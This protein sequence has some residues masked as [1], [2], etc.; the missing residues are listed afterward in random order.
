[1]KSNPRARIGE[2]AK[3]R[4]AGLTLAL[5]ILLA[6]VAPSQA[7]VLAQDDFSDGNYTSSPSWTTV[8]PGL[9][10]VTG[11][12]LKMYNAS[13]AA[14]LALG[15]TMASNTPLMI[16]L[17]LQNEIFNA[18]GHWF[19]LS[20]RDSVSGRGYSVVGSGSPNAFGT[21]PNGSGFGFGNYGVIAAPGVVGQRLN[22][23]TISQTLVL[24][25]DPTTQ[26]VTLTKDGTT[27]ASFVGANALASV[28]TLDLRLSHYSGG[29]ARLV[30][31]ITIS[32]SDP[33]ILAK[34][35][36]ADGD[37]S[38]NPAWTTLNTAFY[39]VV[40]GKLK[41]L[42]GS[43]TAPLSI[44]FAMADDTPLTI[45]LQLQN[46]IF[47]VD[48]HWFMMS[49]RDSVS[50]LGYSV[51]G[52]GL[53]TAFGAGAS[54]SGFGLGNYGTITAPGVP[55]QR[56]NQNT[57]SQNLVLTFDPLTQRVTL[58]K[59]GTTV[60]SFVGANNLASV[61]SLDLR[62]SNY[63]GGPGRFVDDVLI[64]GRRPKADLPPDWVPLGA[65][66]SWE[67]P[68]A[69]AQYR[70]VD[71][72]Q[73]IEDR[74]DQLVENSVDTLWVSNLLEADTPRLIEECEMRGL[75]LI[76]SLNT[77]EAKVP[78]R[79]DSPTYYNTAIPRV[80]NLAGDSNTLAAWVLSDE[81]GS[82]EIAKLEALRQKFRYY[83]PERFCLTVAMWP[84][85][86]AVV[87]QTNHPVFCVDLYPF[88]GPN[89]PNGPHTDSDSRLFFRSKAAVMV[90]SIG[91]GEAVGWVMAQCFSEIWGPRRFD[92]NGHLIGLA[93]SYLHWKCPT[94]AEMRWQ[95]W[96]SLRSGSKGI[97][98]Y[99]VAPEAPNPATETAPSPTSVPPS[100]LATQVTDL[101][102]NALTKPD[103]TATPQLQ[104]LGIAYRRIRPH[105]ALIR[106]WERLDSSLSGITPTTAPL[107]SAT[108]FSD[109][110]TSNRS[111]LVIINDDL[112]QGS[113]IPLCLPLN[114][115]SAED[116]ARGGSL[117]LTSDV[118]NNLRR[119]QVQL[120]AGEGTILRLTR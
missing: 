53:A 108:Y 93:G 20:L 10:Q 37:Y 64:K 94:L 14:P 52:S 91:E 47:N 74:L 27:V 1:M 99:M 6:G 59:D 86:P 89:D 32:T 66:L 81:P 76:A 113:I 21:S 29:P 24:T 100:I 48:G 88:F 4:L 18:D 12:K 79:L 3:S 106:R 40:S 92:V 82:A 25:F 111:Y 43:L 45:S 61:D 83:D 28:D 70:G 7:A 55:G 73:D 34:D 2:I 115:V 49:I 54:A 41:A 11:G 120:Q 36:F 107:A 58:K 71:R 31:D 87:Q 119:T 42:N 60:A 69:L 90:N 104:E 68:T 16:S 72:W 118:A 97:I 78:G 101:G 57:I 103:S 39:Q 56:L 67:R 22:Q 9:Y 77:V 15:F 19:M 116:I 35:D 65:Y 110:Q 30:D 75:R 112:Q 96:E 63:G 26:Q 80:V 50:G 85:V 117:A 8:N 51:T 38:I 46:E 17:Q 23:N 102:P 105:A 114:I 62:L 98:I 33:A 44:G 13:T 95:V 84:Q 5:A 109:P